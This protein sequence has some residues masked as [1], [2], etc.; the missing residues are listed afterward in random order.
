[1][2]D[3]TFPRDLLFTGALF[4]L[5]AFVW[6]G[7][8][9]E[10]PPQGVR[11]R[12]VLVVIQAAGLALLGVGLPP[13]VRN[14]DAS[15]AL[16]PGSPALVWYIVV[17]WVEVIAIAVV[18]VWLVRTKRAELVAAPAMVVVGI[19][20]V[21]LAVVFGQPILMVA[22]VL[23]TAVGVVAFFLPRRVAAPS[24]WCGVLGGPVFLAIGV[25]TLVAG[26]GAI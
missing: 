9:H 20:F 21:P 7:W 26:L 5:V 14:W 12:V 6:A 18:G 19:H 22:A 11:W 25:T 16:V 1:M 15:S 13:L 3:V 17:A 8:A 23:L 10:R 4:G 24:F 2:I